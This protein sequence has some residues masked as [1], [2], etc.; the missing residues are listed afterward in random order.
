VARFVA[1][2]VMVGAIAGALVALVRDHSVW[3]IVLVLVLGLPRRP[4]RA[5]RSAPA[6]RA[7]SAGAT[8][9]P[10]G[11]RCGR[12]HREPEVR[13]RQGRRAFLAEAR[14]RG[15]E[16]I[17]LSAATIW[18]SSPA[19]RLPR[20]R[21]DQD[22]RAATGRRPLSPPSPPSTICRSCASLR[23]RNHTRSTSA[24]TRGRRRRSARSRT[25][26]SAASTS[27]R[28]TAGCS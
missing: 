3:R 1:A 21:R 17:V 6:S 4:W 15:I 12:A 26:M 7:A 18:S 23:H 20:R 28:S 5:P 13:R 8:R 19:A 27:R 9:N 25:A 2:V 24:S 11:C 14:A 22:G 10:R 16:T